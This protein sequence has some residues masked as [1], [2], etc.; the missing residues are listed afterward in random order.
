MLVAVTYAVKDMLISYQYRDQVLTALER[1]KLVLFIGA[2]VEFG[3]YPLWPKTLQLLAQRC[4]IDI[5]DTLSP[6]QQAQQAKTA[7]LMK[8]NETLFETFS[9]WSATMQKLVQALSML[10]PFSILTTNFTD[11]LSDSFE[12]YG[13]EILSYPRI[14]L[15]DFSSNKLIFIHGKMPKSLPSSNDISI[16]IAEDE[17]RTAY[18]LTS[19]MRTVLQDYIRNH[20]M[21]FVGYSFDDTYVV[22][23][24]KIVR[25]TELNSN[26]QAPPRHYALFGV[27]INESR[28]IDAASISN[29][30]QLLKD[31]GVQAI[32]FDSSGEYNDLYELV[33]SWRQPPSGNVALTESTP[34][35]QDTMRLGRSE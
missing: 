27:Q 22:D 16:V 30:G 1:G 9:K 23:L 25:D 2:G 14:K 18:A 8:Y 4:G 35:Q 24:L 26:P 29:K 31:L 33:K 21:L 19:P 7:N 34:T 17:F 12:F 15:E 28:M 10:H 6:P 32:W 3:A 11:I 13:Y 5:D 20:S